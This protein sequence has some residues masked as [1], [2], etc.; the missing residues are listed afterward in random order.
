MTIIMV[1]VIGTAPR[2]FFDMIYLGST[3]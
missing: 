2:A 3:A 1:V